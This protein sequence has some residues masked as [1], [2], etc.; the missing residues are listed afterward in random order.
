MAKGRPDEA[1]KILI[2]YHG[3][4]DENSQL[5]AFEMEE[6]QQAIT[7]DKERNMTWR[8]F[9]SS[10]GTHPFT[11]LQLLFQ[12]SLYHKSNTSAGNW[13]RIALCMCTA[14]FSQ[15]A[16]NSLV[17]NYLTQILKDTGLKTE[18]EITV[19]NACVTMW[20]W[21]V[22]IGVTVFINR[23]GRRKFFLTGSGGCV[24]VFIVWTI[25][26]QQ[27]IDKGNLACGRLVLACIF[28]FQ[29]FYTIAW[30][31]LI[32][33]YPLEISSLRMRAKTWSLVLLTIQVSSIFSGYVNPIGLKNISWKLYIY[34][35]IWL[36]IIFLV[37]Y[38]FFVETAG[39][40][41]EEL[42]YLFDGKEAQEK[43]TLEMKEK[44]EVI[45]EEGT[46]SMDE[47]PKEV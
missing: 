20:Q 39:P 22:S 46:M 18:F 37:V 31:N 11:S 2:K 27:Y 26:S 13:K 35:D 9:F 23:W 16:G 42:S 21:V 40:T 19:V 29:L 34:Y 15:T 44:I 8:D 36:A 45:N 6:I 38:F 47:K 41:L 12:P 43:A 7:D 33:T 24:I 25:A 10:K 30:T 14:V 5:V 4:G 17:S 32:V 28:F 3:E 1:R